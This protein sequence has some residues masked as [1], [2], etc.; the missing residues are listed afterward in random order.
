MLTYAQKKY[1]FAIYK[2]GQNMSEIRLAEVAKTVGV[3]KAS[4]VKM[5]QR[6][7]DDGYII[8]EPYSSLKLTELGMK[9]TSIFFTRCMVIRDFLNKSVGIDEKKADFDAVTMVS[10][11]SEETAEKF[12]QFILNK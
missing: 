6:L 9:E 10:Q 3:S 12:V 4:T 5:M 11:I 2:L 1:L 8:K 7:C